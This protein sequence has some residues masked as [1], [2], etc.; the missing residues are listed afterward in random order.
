MTVPKK[1]AMTAGR[2]NGRM[3]IRKETKGGFYM[4]GEKRA[5]EKRLVRGFNGPVEC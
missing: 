2:G 1:R 4:V 5:T 3:E